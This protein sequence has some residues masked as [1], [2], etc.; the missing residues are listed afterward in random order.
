MEGAPATGT[1]RKSSALAGG[2]KVRGRVTRPKGLFFKALGASV[3]AN[4]ER[5]W[6]GSPPHRAAISRPRPVGL[7]AHPHDPRPLDLD[8]GRQLLDGV[9]LLEGG[10][11]RLGET[12]DPFDQ[13]SPTRQFAAALHGFDWLPHL[14]SAGPGSARLAL[15]LLQDWRRVFGTC[16]AFSWTGER[17][18]RRTFHLA[19]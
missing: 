3:R 5:E 6:F 14:L 10:V 17:L 16:N 18:E 9:M 15:R 4:L 13:P 2:P 11:L 19:C 8:R 1:A 12:G 7:A